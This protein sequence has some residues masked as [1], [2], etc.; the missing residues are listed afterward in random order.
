MKRLLIAA[1]MLA[2]SSAFAQSA[3]SDIPKPKCDKPQMPGEM[4]RSDPSVTRRFN[5]DVDKWTK[6]MKEYIEERQQVMKANEEAANAAIKDYNETVKALNEAG[7][8][9]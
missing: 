6:C 9:K 8:A 5:Q 4:M 3:A 2:A 1:S 7:K